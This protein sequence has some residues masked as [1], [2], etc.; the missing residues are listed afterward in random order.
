MDV[1]SVSRPRRKGGQAIHSLGELEAAELVLVANHAGGGG[2][3]DRNIGD[4]RQGNRGWKPDFMYQASYVSKLKN[5]DSKRNSS[6]GLSPRTAISI[7]ETSE[8]TAFKYTVTKIHSIRYF[9]HLSLFWFWFRVHGSSDTITLRT[10]LQRTLLQPA[11]LFSKF[12][13]G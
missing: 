11:Q 9:H 13:T 8:E 7:E 3:S 10:L 12:E 4:A 5:A 2:R 1:I 6:K